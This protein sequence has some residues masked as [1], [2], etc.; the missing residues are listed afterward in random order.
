ME[1]VFAYIIGLGAAVMMPIIFTVLGVCIGIKFSKALKS[2]LY[3]GVGFVG[4]GVI[5]GLLTSSLGPALSKV[6]EIYGLELNVFDMGW[7]AAASVAYNTTVGAFIIPV[8]LA[9]NLVLLLLGC[10]RTI[11]IDLWNY[12]HF[13]FIG[14]V[15]YFLTDSIGWGFFAAIICYIVTLVFADMT[16][17]KFQQFYSGMEGISIPQPFC[18]GFTPFAILIGKALD[19]IPG[20]DKLNIDAE[21]MKKKFGLF[22]EPLFLGVIIGIVIGCFACESWDAVV[23]GIP[24]IL[25]LG[26]KMGAVMELIPRITSLFIEGLKPIS[27][28]TRE[29]IAKKFGEKK[30]FYIGMSPALV[31]GHPTT[32]IVSLL[33][34][35]VTLILAVALPGNQ[36]LPL[37]SLAGMFYVFVMVLPYTR[38]NVVKSFIVGLV[39]MAAGLYFVTLMSENFTSAAHVVSAAHPDDAAVRVPEGFKA[40]SLDFASSPI[41]FAIYAC[42]KYLKYIGAGILSLLTIILVVWNRKRI[43]K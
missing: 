24:G 29:L 3:V 25:G 11:N 10:T 40:G 21:G 20:F 5:T 18:Q 43:N 37:A 6:V 13:A 26:I 31:I 38:G 4:L 36:F 14:A 42:M 17:K 33:L 1:Q 28:A 2:G 34:I 19:L 7:P 39:V 32:L 30:E 23:D 12:W 16:A 35:P 8:C 15:I 22:G 9:V 27:E 41:A